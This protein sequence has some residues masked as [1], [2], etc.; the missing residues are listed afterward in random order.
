[1]KTR[2]MVMMNDSYGMPRAWGIADKIDDARAE[3]KRQ[4]DKYIKRK[5]EV[6]EHYDAS[7]F[8]EE[9]RTVEG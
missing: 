9:T 1:M 6:G 5:A 7:D 4:L 8:T 3:A 2:K